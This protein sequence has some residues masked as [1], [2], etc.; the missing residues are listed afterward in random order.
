MH[1]GTSEAETAGND[2][3]HKI[4]GAVLSKSPRSEKECLSPACTASDMTE[5]R[6]MA[7]L[8]S[9][10]EELTRI[11]AASIITARSNRK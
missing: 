4:G 11:L 8:I 9:E 10:A 1:C 2:S 7:A 3:V 5:R 6:R